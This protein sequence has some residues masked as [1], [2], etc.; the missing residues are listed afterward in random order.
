MIGEQ[1]IQSRVDEYLFIEAKLEMNLEEYLNWKQ[2]AKMI[3]KETA[4]DPDRKR[5]LERWRHYLLEKEK[6]NR[7]ITAAKEDWI[8][9]K[10]GVVNGLCY[11][12]RRCEFKATIKYLDEHQVQK[13]AEMMVSY[14]RVVEEYVHLLQTSSST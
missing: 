9:S 2:N 4:R 8:L 13:E 5:W 7:C 3:L 14:A 1:D 10:D 12:P 6:Y 11:N